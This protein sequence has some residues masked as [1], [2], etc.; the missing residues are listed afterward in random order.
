MKPKNQYPEGHKE[1]CEC[2]HPEYNHTGISYTGNGF[3]MWAN[4]SCEK[5]IPQNNSPKEKD[6][7][8]LEGKSRESEDKEP[9]ESLISKTSGS[10]NQEGYK[11]FS[12]S[13]KERKTLSDCLVFV[14][15]Q[16]QLDLTEEEF[17]ILHHKLGKE[18][19]NGK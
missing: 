18:L 2:G 10:D 11:E 14:G 6:A 1:I 19:T 16:N 8:L 3:C 7:N 13:E 5:F 17:E 9:E 12:L 4:C 15:L